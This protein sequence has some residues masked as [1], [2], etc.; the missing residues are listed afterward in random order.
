V[1]SASDPHDRYLYNAEKIPFQTH[2]ISGNVVAQDI[3]PG[4]YGTVAQEL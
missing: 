2:Y 1:V 4:T 3:E